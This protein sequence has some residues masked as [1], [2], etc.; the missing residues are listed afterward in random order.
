MHEKMRNTAQAIIALCPLP[1]RLSLI[2]GS[3]QGVYSWGINHGLITREEY[4]QAAAYH[5]R[6]F[7]YAGD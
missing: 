7:N 4:D 5:G 2:Y 3:A 6:G 1:E